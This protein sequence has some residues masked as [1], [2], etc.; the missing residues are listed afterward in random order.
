MN[1]M[2]HMGCT[3]KT[4]SLIAAHIAYGVCLTANSAKNY[5]KYG[6]AWEK[7]V[8][9]G[10]SGKEVHLYFEFGDYFSIIL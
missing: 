9:F 8:D 4:C 7:L 3:S 5:L 1:V 2:S 10:L 6:V